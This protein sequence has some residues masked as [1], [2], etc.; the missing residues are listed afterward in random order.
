MSINNIATALYMLSVKLNVVIPERFFHN[1]NIAT[2]IAFLNEG[3][4]FKTFVVND[5]IMI[6]HS[7]NKIVSFNLGDNI[8]MSVTPAFVTASGSYRSMTGA[9]FIESDGAKN[10]FF[11][12]PRSVYVWSIR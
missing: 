4:D 3:A 8:S 10:Y 12:L 11:L 9:S 5:K 1:E 7:P 6:L 2:I